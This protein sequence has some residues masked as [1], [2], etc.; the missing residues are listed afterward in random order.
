MEQSDATVPK[1]VL[2]QTQA[3]AAGAQEVSRILGQGLQAKG[4]DVHY[5]YLFRRT[6]AFDLQSNAFFCALQRP[7]GVWTLLQMM[8]VLV[9]HLKALQPDVVLCFQHY[10]NLVGVLAGRL[11]G[12]GA[13]I[14]NRNTA[15]SLVPRWVQLLDLML[16]SVGLFNA[17]VITR[18][19]EKEY[20]GY[21]SSYQSRIARIDHGFA[22]KITNLN[23]DAA[24]RRLGLP[25]EAPLLGSVARLHP[26]KNLAAAI[27]LLSH[28][29]T[30]HLAL[31]GQGPE[32]DRLAQL[33]ASLGVADRLHFMGELAT[34]EVA[35]FLRSLDVFVFPSMAEVFPLAVVEAAQ[36][37]V[38]VVS[39]NLDVVNEVLSIDGEPCALFADANDTASFA[40]AVRR[41][42]D[43]TGLAATL[44]ARAAKLAD[45]Y[46]L[47]VMVDAYVALIES[48]LRNR[49]SRGDR[50]RAQALPSNAPSSAQ[51]T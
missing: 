47:D 26:L 22:P 48:E 39:N 6:A 30:W 1:I 44:S 24:R 29:R 31:A 20:R 45:R 23:R 36:A 40:A 42:L 9:R 19:V 15:K 10:G 28:D 17:I 38:P 21:P 3:E 34:D 27:R 13:I 12:V 43:D 25:V 37:G 11:A 32:R 41:L 18:T 50:G 5:V 7:N 46:S 35:A 14:T 2:L 4:Y 33:A 49:A 51:E 16:G 8:A